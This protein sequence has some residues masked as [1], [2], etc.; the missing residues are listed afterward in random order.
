MKKLLGILGLSL[1]VIIG[2]AFALNVSEEPKELVTVNEQAEEVETFV[3][4]NVGNGE[5]YKYTITEVNE[6]GIFGIPLNKES[7]GN[8]GI[9]LL[10][11]EL[12]F[13]A[14]EGDIIE[15]VWG[16]EEDVFQ[17]IKKLN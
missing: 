4:D 9:F 3:N 15:V 13:T 10:E 1:V 14:D 11:D 7:E 5:P 17:S 8:R 2:M 12:D 16:E 6:E